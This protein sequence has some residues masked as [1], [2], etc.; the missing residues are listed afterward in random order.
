VDINLDTIAQQFGIKPLYDEVTSH[1]SKA[2][3]VADNG[4][5]YRDAQMVKLRRESPEMRVP[6]AIP[7]F[8]TSASPMTALVWLIVVLLAGYKAAQAILANDLTSLVL[9][10]LVVVATAVFI[11]IMN[12]WRRGFY[13]LIGWILFEDL[14]R[15]FLGNN[16]AIY[17]AKDVLAIILY[18]AFYKNYLAKQR[19]KLS[20]PFRLSLMVF[21]WFCT[22]QVFNPASPSIFYGILGMKI[23]FLYVPLIYVAYA[24][25]ESESDLRRFFSFICVLILIVTG[26]GLAQSIIGPAFLNPQ[27]LQDDIR[28][29]STLYRVAPISGLSAYRPTSVFVSAGRFQDFLVVSWLISLSYGGYLLLHTR[30]GRTLAF[31]TVGVVAAASV[32]SASRGVFMWNA[33]I[34]LVV[35]A[36][37]LWGAPWRKREVVRVIRAIQRSVLFAGIAIILLLVLFPRELGSRMAIYSETLLPNSP[38]SELVRRTQTYPLTQLKYAF[39]YPRWPYGYGIGTC[40]LGTQYVARILHVQPLG[41]GV[42]SGYG[43][44]IVELG[45]VGLILWLILGL[46]ISLSAWKVAKE[47]KGTPWFPLAFVVFFFCVLLYFPMTFVSSGTYQDYV[48]SAYFWLLTG[49]LYRLPQFSRASGLQVDS[50][51]PGNV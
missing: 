30:K 44:L 35:V 1:A 21:F 11:V 22:L 25:A 45:I 16:M 29:L 18:L 41:I 46:S 26:L 40:S 37:F 34:T 15:K 51:L 7:S 5:G 4:G 28:D 31:T 33:G 12:D 39:D 27:T 8:R 48:I 14:V 17:F 23:D 10:G 50:A 42:E 43:N 36:G 2:L 24:F 32:M 38:T 49:F 20:I 9:A 19:E 47:L 6:A 3:L 13:L